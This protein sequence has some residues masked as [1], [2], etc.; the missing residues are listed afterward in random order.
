MIETLDSH[1]ELSG[2]AEVA[3]AC[4]PHQC[5]HF[6]A[7]AADLR[8]CVAALRQREFDRERANSGLFVKRLQRIVLLD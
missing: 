3:L 7:Q 6:V 1:H 4:L 8:G 5:K 2:K